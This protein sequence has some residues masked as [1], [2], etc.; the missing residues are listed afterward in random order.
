MYFVYPFIRL[1]VTLD[2]S[3]G[4]RTERTHSK[5]HI[6]N[7]TIPHSVMQQQHTTA[8][9]QRAHTAP[10]T[11]NIT[12]RDGCTVFVKETENREYNCFAFEMRV[13]V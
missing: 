12:I 8:R 11:V 4:L 2:M 7:H 3:F 13:R 10:T 9:I 5:R 1:F 6:T